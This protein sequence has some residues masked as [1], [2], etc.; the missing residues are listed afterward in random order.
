MKG[1]NEKNLLKKAMNKYLPKEII[2]RHKQPYRAPDMK[3]MTGSYLG[4]ELQHYLS[5]N[6]LQKNGL[7]DS[8][9]VQFLLKKAGSGRA[10]STPESQAL[11]GI[12]STQIVIE[13]FI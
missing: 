5:P 7:F 13:Q 3:V 8:S 12:L 4:D 6:E 10:L 11:V 9:K 1:L 2:H